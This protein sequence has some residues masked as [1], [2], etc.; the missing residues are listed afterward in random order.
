VRSHKPDGPL[1]VFMIPL[2]VVVGKMDII[3]NISQ[4]S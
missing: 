1:V 2:I 3:R 4:E